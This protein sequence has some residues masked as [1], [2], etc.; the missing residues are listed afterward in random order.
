[1][2]LIPG[3]DN[4]KR[5]AWYHGSNSK[6]IAGE[7]GTAAVHSTSMRVLGISLRYVTSRVVYVIR[8]KNVSRG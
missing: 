1:M 7:D 3:A 4:E 8:L 2:T 6:A 5:Y